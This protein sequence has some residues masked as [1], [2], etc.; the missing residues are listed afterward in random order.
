[1]PKKD[2]K[3]KDPPPKELSLEEKATSLLLSIVYNIITIIVVICVGVLSVTH[4]RFTQTNLLPDCATAIPFTN[5]PITPKQVHIDYISNQCS[6]GDM[7]SIKSYYPV[8]Y[9]KKII[10][11]SYLY[12]VIRI[13]TKSPHSNVIGNY[14]GS[15]FATMS[16]NYASV[17][18]SITSLFNSILPELF[19]FLFG[20][21]FIL[22]AHLISIIYATILGIISFFTYAKLFFYK[23]EIVTLNDEK[24]A[25]WKEGAY[26]MW[27]GFNIFY[28]LFIYFVLF[29]GVLPAITPAC[30]IFSIFMFLSIS[31]TPFFLLR[32]YSSTKDIDKVIQSNA[33]KMAFGVTDDETNMSG[34]GAIEEESES[35]T[36]SRNGNA[37]DDED[38]NVNGQPHP[39][40]PKRFTL[41]SH[42]K[43]FVKVYRNFIIFAMSIM[44]AIDIWRL[45]GTYALWVTVFTI[46]L[47]WL[48]SEVYQP[49]KIKDADK[50][51]TF[52]LGTDQAEKVCKTGE[53]KPDDNSRKWYFLWLM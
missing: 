41:F 52:L 15:I 8:N 18:T 9:N 6:K 13:L 23:K 49:Y 53:I 51:T 29:I 12:K 37:S 17:Y 38:G 5:V 3:K 48:F 36:D 47:L 7:C 50:F 10:N 30:T 32:L 27:D 16:Q 31:L 35:N 40:M 28:S 34:G 39:N 43:K 19:I 14:I 45:F 26:G 2:K 46:V 4:M 1:M 20:T 25:E 21:I 22:G 11:G 44:L 33:S 42:F 24:F